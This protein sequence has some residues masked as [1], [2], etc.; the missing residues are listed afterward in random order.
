MK[1]DSDLALIDRKNKKIIRIVCWSIAF[2]VMVIYAA[3]WG[4]GSLV[5]FLG[6]VLGFG[7]LFV[8]AFFISK[9]PHF[10]KSLNEPISVKK[11]Y[12]QV[13]V[14]VLFLT[15]FLLSIFWVS[16]GYSYFLSKFLNAYGKA[17]YAQVETYDVQKSRSQLYRYE[18]QIR[19]DNYT[20][21][22]QVT[23]DNTGYE[24]IVQNVINHKPI[25]VHY[26]KWAPFIVQP[27][28]Y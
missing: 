20:T 24:P 1:N 12:K 25:K 27:V 22:M 16:G 15:I 4:G 18:V 28:N 8:A 6:Y 17:A 21:T 26:L 7:I 23:S 14:A 3:T 10:Y 5:A 2:A 13:P 19:Y 9:H 11:L